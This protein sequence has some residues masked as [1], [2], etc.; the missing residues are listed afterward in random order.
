MLNCV[1]ATDGSIFMVHPEK[2]ATT[3]AKVID[4]TAIIY[5][6]HVSSIIL[7]SY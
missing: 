3:I 7:F 1:F 6:F 5:I 4:N 2:R